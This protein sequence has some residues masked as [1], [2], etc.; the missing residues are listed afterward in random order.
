MFQNNLKPI[1]KNVVNKCKSSLYKIINL[2]LC[3]GRIVREREK[4]HF[5]NKT[6]L[7]NNNKTG[8]AQTNFFV[9]PKVSKNNFSL[10]IFSLSCCGLKNFHQETFS[11]FEDLEKLFIRFFPLARLLLQ[12]RQFLRTF[13]FFLVFQNWMNFNFFN[14]FTSRH[15]CS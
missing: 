7:Q 2:S 1:Y 12:P 9:I 8:N 11:V 10:F 5:K 3:G 14:Y 4:H 6:T 15:S 13:L